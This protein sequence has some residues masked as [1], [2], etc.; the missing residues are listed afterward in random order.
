MQSLK[1]LCRTKEMRLLTSIAG[2]LVLWSSG[3][4]AF[5]LPQVR[6]NANAFPLQA[7]IGRENE[8]RR[9]IAQMKRQGKIAN[10]SSRDDGKVPVA[11]QYGD[12][13][14]KKL[15][16]KKAKLMG[17]A[18]VVKD[19]DIIDELAEEDE[20]ELRQTVEDASL[21]DDDDDEEEMADVHLA[22]IVAQK[23]REKRQR[24]EEEV[25]ARR[26]EKA[27]QR[28]EKMERE[29]TAKQQQD[30]DGNTTTGIGGTFT[31]EDEV[32]TYKP[33]KSGTWGVFERPK[34]I[35][36][37]YGGGRRVGIGITDQ[38]LETEEEREKR[39]EEMYE[40]SGIRPKSEKE[41][42]DEIQE[43]MAIAKKAMQVGQYPVGV[44]ALEKV[45]Q[46]CSTNSPV[47]G[48]VFLELGMAYDAAGRKKLAIKV[49]NKL[50]RSRQ[51]DIK[52]DAR[53]LL[54]NVESYEFMKSEIG[55]GEF[56]GKRD[57][58]FKEVETIPWEVWGDP[59][60]GYA[61]KP[62]T[63]E[64]REREKRKKEE[65]RKALE[66]SSYQEARKV[67]FEATKEFVHKEAKVHNA[68]AYI[69]ADFSRA[70]TWERERTKSN[71]RANIKREKPE[72]VAMM[73]GEPLYDEPLPK[74]K[75]APEPVAG[76]FELVSEEHMK[77]NLSGEW[78]L[79][80]IAD[81]VQYKRMTYYKKSVSRQTISTETMNFTSFA[82]K[83]VLN[84]AQTG[85]I[86]FQA[87]DRILKRTNVDSSLGVFSGIL[88]NGGPLGAISTPHYVLAVD[89]DLLITRMVVVEEKINALELKNQ[90]DYYAV[91][92]RRKTLSLE[93]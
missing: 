7:G 18:S 91:W 62:R 17:A 77:E 5:V 59:Y 23:M 51:D 4:C 49:Y 63:K 72:V 82:P 46:W 69:S 29:E 44:S 57:T 25:E 42:A 35:S 40:E 15:G 33:S 87:E 80:L 8:I 30:T 58:S 64:D 31:K 74:A 11:E 2:L 52:K 60:D 79:Q 45:S 28:L 75:V 47:G 70:M 1:M 76:G 68:L 67:L 43:A 83:G 20:E 73:D 22:R 93:P 84:V 21:D 66:C 36:K 19:D 34:D 16:T 32:E 9:K 56:S 54:Y 10:Q 85:N 26:Q 41:H 86:E 12:R 53:R 48:K 3:V 27:R 37:A 89:S 81:K 71:N 13:L 61:Y 50:S 65:Q 38:V 55:T 92:R 78:F 88:S 24:E 90:K 39:I 6:T 14:R